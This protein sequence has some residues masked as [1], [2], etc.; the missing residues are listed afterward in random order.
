VKHFGDKMAKVQLNIEC[1]D[2]FKESFERKIR[3]F[4][5]STVS[6]AVRDLMR[7]FMEEKPKSQE[8]SGK[9]A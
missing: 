6:E 8:E 9:V 1:E 4:G 2:S 3:L 5:Y 7:R